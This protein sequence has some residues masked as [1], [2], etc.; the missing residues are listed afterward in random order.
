MALV[1]FLLIRELVKYPTG[2]LLR[3]IF[4]PCLFLNKCV[5][6][7]LSKNAVPLEKE[8]PIVGFELITSIMAP[9]K[10]LLVKVDQAEFEI[11]QG[12]ESSYYL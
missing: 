8:V 3:L 10:V 12:T 6:M 9:V 5:G 7:E 11:E 1:R 4:I 2:A